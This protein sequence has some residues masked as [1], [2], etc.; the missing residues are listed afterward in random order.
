VMRYCCT[1]SEMTRRRHERKVEKAQR[2]ATSARSVRQVGST[3]RL[4]YSIVQAAE[5]LGVDPSTVSRSVMPFVET[6]EVTPGRR[7]IPVDELERY[8][9]ERR[10][11]VRARRAA[12]GRPPS[13]PD[14]VVRRIRAEHAAGR[15][16]G[17]IARGLDA[18]G[19]PTAQ[20][21]RRWWSSSVRAVLIRSDPPSSR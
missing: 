3:E 21:G 4:A 5:V 10:R 13:V 7:L 17:Q 9:A 1:V 15:T 2:H 18:D 16:L 6:I 12:V 11:P 19:V 14:E 8:V 20:N